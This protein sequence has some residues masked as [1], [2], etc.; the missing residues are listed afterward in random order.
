[1]TLAT[2]WSLWDRFFFAPVSPY[3]VA[4]LRIFLSLMIL[5]NSLF[6]IDDFYLW[7]GDRGVTT[8][9]TVIL[10]SSNEYLNLLNAVPHNDVFL[11][12]AFIVF[13]IAA[14][15][16]GIGYQT[17]IAS[18]VSFLL[19]TSFCSRNPYYLNSGDTF[20]KALS[21]WLMFAESG[22]AWSVDSWLRKKKEKLDYVQLIPAWGWRC[23]QFQVAIV[24]YHAFVTKSAAPVWME[25]TAVY[26]AS[27]LEGL[28]RM[29]SPVP[30]DT[31]LTSLVFTWL[32]L[33][34]ELALFTLI[35]VRDVR[36]YL[37]AC[38]IIMHLIIDWTMNIP[39]YEWTMVLSYVLFVYPED[40]VRFVDWS[41]SALIGLR[42]GRHDD[43]LMAPRS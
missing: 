12:A 42:S 28:Y 40:L 7:L 29:P 20:I 31:E 8:S 5:Q 36:Y 18:V 14:I 15:C 37:L 19:I 27:R 4:A 23:L 13:N 2:L 33:I 25:G 38:A 30:L 10:N 11:T 24:Y 35:W 1:M 17:R 3:P 34:I 43:T 21:F 16:L 39:Q 6:L 32:T 22:A 41:K 9:N 26:I